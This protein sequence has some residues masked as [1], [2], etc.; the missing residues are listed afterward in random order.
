MS[1]IR[2]NAPLG[3]ALGLLG[4]IVMRSVI[5]LAFGVAAGVLGFFA[6]WAALT[7]QTGLAAGVAIL[8]C[9]T[10]VGAGI[11]SFIGWL[12]L[13]RSRLANLPTMALTVTGGLLGAWGGLAYATFVYD[14]DVKTQDARITAVAGAAFAA[15]L[16][17]AVWRLGGSLLRRS[18]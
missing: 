15:N 5:G 1:G 8:T 12:D 17:P 11:G 14:V 7:P 4:S 18:P 16:V 13:D 3:R 2:F 6:G 9:G 10:G